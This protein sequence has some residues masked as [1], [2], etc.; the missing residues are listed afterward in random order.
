MNKERLSGSKSGFRTALVDGILTVLLILGDLLTKMLAGSYL[1]GNPSKPLI[2]G[3]LSLVYVENTGMAF[4]LLK[5]GRFLFL[6]ICAL[7]LP[8]MFL[9]YRRIP[10]TRRY[11][12]LRIS[13]VLVA[14]GAVGNALDR[15]LRGYVVDF[16]CTDFID[17]PVFNLADCY[18]VGGAI[19]LAVLLMFF[20]E[21]GELHV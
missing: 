9:F 2:P 1:K 15:F 10:K 14:S 21:E 7:F 12:P 18:V 6:L 8:F 19:L 5:G 3:I 11:M 13:A 20:Y 16:I 17:F 4:G